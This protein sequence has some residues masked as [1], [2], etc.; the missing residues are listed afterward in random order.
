MPDTPNNPSNGAADGKVQLA[1]FDIDGTLIEGQSPAIVARCLFMKGLLGVR[2]AA[3]AIV[4]GIR[5]ELG[6]TLET[7]MVRE[8]VFGTLAGMPLDE[9]NAILEDIYEHHIVGKE[10]KKAVDRI[11]WHQEH[12]EIVVL[13]SATF[14]YVAQLFAD[15]LGVHRQTST[16]MEIVDG[17]YTGRVAGLPDE[18]DEKPVRLKAHADAEFGEGNWEV[19][20]SYADHLTDIPIL[21]MA[22]HPVV[23]CPK[24][25]FKKV[26][27]ERGWQIVEW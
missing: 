24:R 6:F 9:A 8:L 23:V 25:S 13:V 27:Q 14:Q 22:E 10:R 16:E 2:R 5:Y 26:A 21:E 3:K 4:W 17:C 11:H 12:G 20:Y 19:A 1:V 7:T 15:D 18:G